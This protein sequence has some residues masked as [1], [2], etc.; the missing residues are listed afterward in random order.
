MV[1]VVNGRR[2]EP[3]AVLVFNSARMA[4]AAAK[5]LGAQGWGWSLD[6]H[7]IGF[8]NGKPEIVGPRWRLTL[9]DRA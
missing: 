5:D 8:V 2:V 4:M 1:E 7:D 6:P 3:G 9:G